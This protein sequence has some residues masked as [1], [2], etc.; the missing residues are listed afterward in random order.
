MVNVIAVDMDGTFLNSNNDYNREYFDDL[1]EIMSQ[2][3]I[4]FVVASG[5]QYAQLRSFFPK[6]WRKMTFVSENGALIFKNDHLIKKKVINRKLVKEILDL[7]EDSP[8]E[9]SVIL[10]GIKGAY[11][12]KEENEDF[13]AFAGQYYYELAELDSFDNLPEDDFVKFALQVKD[14]EAFEIIAAIN[15]KSDAKISAV[16]SGHGSVDLVG[17][18]SNKGSALEFLLK[19]WKVTSENLLAFGES[20]NDL[21]MLHLAGLSYAMENGTDA[22]LRT[23]EYIA[24]S[25]DEEGVLSIIEKLII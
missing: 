2:K 20:N 18:T 12:L 10:C 14:E 11:L 17:N 4:E 23:A 16:Y 1:F 9:V 19:D 13:K 25:N 22:V 21:E 6:Q 7:L 24:P 8:M 15:E 5:N 3:G